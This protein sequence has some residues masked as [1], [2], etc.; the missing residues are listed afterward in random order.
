MGTAIGVILT[1]YLVSH[2]HMNGWILGLLMLG[3]TYIAKSL[4]LD[5]TVLHQVA[6]TILLVFTFERKSKDY[7]LKALSEFFRNFKGIQQGE[8]NNWKEK[9]QKM[10]LESLHSKMLLYPSP[11]HKVYKDSFYLETKELIKNL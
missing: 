11:S 1:A 4:R 5:E 7:D 3:G 9:E 8:I 10:L 6:L 2:L